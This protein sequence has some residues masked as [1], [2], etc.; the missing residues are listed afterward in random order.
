MILTQQPQQIKIHKPL[1]NGIANSL[2]QI[3]NEDR[4]SDK[5]LEKLFKQ[6]KQWGSRD[7]KFIAES[8]YDI[9]RHYRLLSHLAQSKN[10]YWFITSVYFVLKNIELPDWPEFK[11]VNKELILTEYGNVKNDFG[12]FNSYPKELEEVCIS[13]L[14][15]ETWEKEALAM[16]AQADVVLRVNT[17]KTNTAELQKKLLEEGIETEK[18]KNNDDALILKKRAN[19]FSNKYFKEG[20]FE[21]QDRGSQEIVRFC[22]AEPKQFVIDSCAGAGGKSLALAAAMQNKGR[23]VSMD[24]AQ[25]KLDEATK[26]AKRAGVFNLETKLI[27]G[28]KVI[29]RYKEKADLVLLD[30]PCSG[31]G[32]I[33][34]NPDTKWKFTKASFEKTKQLQQQ[35][36]KDHCNMV[37]A[38]G[39]L[40]YST[41]SILPSENEAQVQEFLKENQNFTF[42]SEKH[43][44]PS[45][46]SDG[47]YMCKLKRK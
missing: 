30:V 6:N 19:V 27:D 5:V 36:L 42:V 7:R 35:I 31:L 15:K 1:L 3:F 28:P 13:E 9:V 29:E 17:L 32:V 40:V 37:K 11:H 18:V 34:R 39:T 14:G 8:V 2:A 33:K 43:I 16:N 45:E 46:G 22:A 41:C 47:F 20:F 24:V 21:I 4:Y 12:L 26:R 38:G 10:N 23:I 25:W 44:Y